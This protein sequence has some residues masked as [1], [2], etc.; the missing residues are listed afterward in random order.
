MLFRRGIKLQ[1]GDQKE[2][3]LL[4]K[5]VSLHF[6]VTIESCRV[7][8][9]YV[10]MFNRFSSCSTV[11]TLASEIVSRLYCI[12]STANSSAYERSFANRSTT[13]FLGK[14]RTTTGTKSFGFRCCLTSAHHVRLVGVI[15]AA[16][17]LAK[18]ADWKRSKIYWSVTH[19]CLHDLICGTFKAYGACEIFLSKVAFER[20]IL[21]VAYLHTAQVF[22]FESRLAHVTT[23]L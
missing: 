18:K 10:C 1:I 17:T 23:V 6:A 19:W 14:L 4:N 22:T 13:F 20:K 16:L 8:E 3:I 2:V 15:I 11:K 7:V 12:G 9:C 5:R 21:Y